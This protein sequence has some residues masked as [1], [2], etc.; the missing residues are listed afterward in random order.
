V[1]EFRRLL[2]RGVDDLKTHLS[3]SLPE[4]EAEEISDLVGGLGLPGLI[5]L[6]GTSGT[7][8][9]PRSASELD[10]VATQVASELVGRN[11]SADEVRSLL[12]DTLLRGSPPDDV[13]GD[14][15]LRDEILEKSVGRLAA[16]AR[17]RVTPAQAREVARLLATGGFYRDVGDTTATALFVVRGLPLA[18]HRD[19]RGPQRFG[20]VV[21]A[22]A[23]DLGSGLFGIPKILK[24]L[25][26]DG[27][28]DDTPAILNKTL[29]V[30][31]SFATIG[32]TAEMIQELI[33][34]EHESVRLAIVIYARAHGIPIED[35]DL[36][37]VRETLFNPDHPDLGPALGRAIGYLA[38]HRDLG[39]IKQMLGRMSKAN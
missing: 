34:P 24:D 31:Y 12:T 9:T 6:L 36:D 21:I 28:L 25:G 17:M 8:M 32:S 13:M 35:A 10:E 4:S 39:E 30:L 38:E 15:E 20:R 37:I 26:D 7:A 27:K 1:S 29:G 11:V 16:K 22:M 19:M 18:L 23:Q 3:A 5:G 14:R 2:E 33:K